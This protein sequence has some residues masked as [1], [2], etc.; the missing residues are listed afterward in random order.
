MKKNPK[1]KIKKKKNNNMKRL[2]ISQD[3]YW[4]WF[5]NSTFQK[6]VESSKESKKSKKHI[7][8]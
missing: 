4:K 5:G 2:S 7:F 8:F 6:N 3:Y 1:H